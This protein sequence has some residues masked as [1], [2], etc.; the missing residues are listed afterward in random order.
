MKQ[1]FVQGPF[2]RRNSDSKEI[3]LPG[4]RKHLVAMVLCAIKRNA[5][6]FRVD[7]MNGF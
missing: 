3:V 2:L 4:E 7:E 1:E 6:V 5:E